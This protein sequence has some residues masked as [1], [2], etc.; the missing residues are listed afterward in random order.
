MLITLHNT[1]PKKPWVARLTGRDPK[2]VLAREFVNGASQYDP[3]S[4][5]G[6]NRK[7]LSKTYDL[8]DGLYEISSYGRRDMHDRYFLEVYD[9][10]A[11][12]RRVDMPHVM[13]TLVEHETATPSA[14]VRDVIRK[15][16]LSEEE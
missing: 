6:P 16:D 14:V 9:E 13:K 3:S 8:P 7:W 4:P 5:E 1:G 12:S 10:G 11:S 2:Y 15:L